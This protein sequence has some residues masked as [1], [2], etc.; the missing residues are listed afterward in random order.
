M[1][2]I[3]DYKSDGRVLVVPEVLSIS[4][5]EGS[6]AGGT[7]L[8]ITGTGLQGINA[9]PAV[10]IGGK[11]CQVQDVTPTSVT[12]LT[13]ASDSATAANFNLA[14]LGVSIEEFVCIMYVFIK[15]IICVH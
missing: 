7:L 9:D 4:P 5:V 3:P 2:N 1:I 10:L 6:L 12:C 15:V 14:V 11:V 13:P 8:T